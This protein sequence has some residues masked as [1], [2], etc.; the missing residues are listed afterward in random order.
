VNNNNS[1]ILTVGINEIKQYNLG[2]YE[3]EG[4]MRKIRKV[5]GEEKWLLRRN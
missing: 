3:A 1:F 5:K 2:F 4:L